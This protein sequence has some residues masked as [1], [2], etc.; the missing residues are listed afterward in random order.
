MKRK[1]LYGLL[2]L[3]IILLSG[4]SC[5]AQKNNLFDSLPKNLIKINPWGIYWGS[6]SIS[7]ERFVGLKN[8]FEISANFKY[9]KKNKFIFSDANELDSGMIPKA[10][11]FMTMINFRHYFSL[12]HKKRNNFSWFYYSPFFR[13]SYLNFSDTNEDFIYSFK[14]NSFKTGM[15]IGLMK[16]F[17]KIVVDAFIGPQLI[18]NNNGAGKYYNLPWENDSFS[19]P[20][21]YVGLGIRGGINIGYSF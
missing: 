8:S 10:T 18:F 15:T 20:L 2:A 6:Y 4:N 11:G 7:Y 12:F 3:L 21:Y 1:H 16:T 14:I 17:N 9:N 5:L 19:I 13:Y